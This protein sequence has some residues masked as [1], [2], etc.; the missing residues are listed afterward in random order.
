MKLGWAAL[1][2]IAYTAFVIHR[3]MP[4]LPAR[5]P[6]SFDFQGRPTAGSSPDTL[7]LMLAIQVAVTALILSV[8][9]IGRRAPQWVNL[10]WKRLS[11]YPLAAR[12]RIMPLLEEMSGW[13]AVLFSSFF[14]VL[15]REL[16]RAALD[17]GK[18]PSVW[19]V[20]FFLAGTAG[21]TIYYMIQINRAGKEAT[22][23]PSGPPPDRK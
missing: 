22:L 8:P 23:L 16:L 14:T 13:M 20:W 21:I 1:A 11:D 12:Q 15:I 2:L 7:W 3:A 4:R 18:S 6:T 9:A 5:I 17:P 10:G 19:P